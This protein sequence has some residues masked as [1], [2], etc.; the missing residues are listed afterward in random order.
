VV[1]TNNGTTTLNPTSV[2]ITGPSASH[3]SATTTGC[4]NLATLATCAV[5]LTFSATALG[6]YNATL[7]VTD[8]ALSV[9]QTLQLTVVVGY[10]QVVATPSYASFP[11]DQVVGT[12]SAPQTLTIAD[13]NGN[14]LDHPITA[15]FPAGS[16]FTLPSGSSC[17]ASATEVCTLT[18]GFAP[19]SG[20]GFSQNLTITDLTSGYTTAVSVYGSAV[21]PPVVGLSTSAVSF[22]P[23]TVGSSSTAMSVTVTDTGLGPLLISGISITGADKSSFSQN[24]NCGNM[25]AGGYC[26]INVSFD[27]QAQGPLGATLQIVSNAPSSPDLVSLSGTGQP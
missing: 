18:F 11:P 13:Q 17:P 24:N 6:T 26:T 19:Q 14:P 9:S 4:A 12:V 21:Y 22:S 2:S 27:P 16:P 7:T 3:Y 15:T 1:L 20:G 10:S 25:T 5:N 8:T 23:L